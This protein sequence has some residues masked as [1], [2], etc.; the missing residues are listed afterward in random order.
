MLGKCHTKDKVRKGRA[1]PRTKY[2]TKV[3]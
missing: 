2:I 3:P 1:T